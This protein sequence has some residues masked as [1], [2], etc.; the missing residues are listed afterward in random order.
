MNIIY[1]PEYGPEYGLL[2]FKDPNLV[3]F[4]TNHTL[5][6]GLFGADYENLGDNYFSFGF[7]YIAKV[8]PR[9]I[10]STI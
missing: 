5:E 7:S 8:A 3:Y 9:S 1:W 2:V 6:H 4:Q 10:L